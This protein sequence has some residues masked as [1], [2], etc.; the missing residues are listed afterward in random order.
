[1]L[2][3]SLHQHRGELD[4]IPK[5]PPVLTENAAGYWDQFCDV[6]LE[7]NH[8]CGEYLHDIYEMCWRIDLREKLQED[9]DQYGLMN[10]YDNGL[11]PNG[12]S[13]MIDKNDKR[14]TDLKKMY[15]LTLESRQ[16]LKGKEKKKSE[17]KPDKQVRNTGLKVVKDW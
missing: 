8:L 2:T 14:I 7:H 5:A 4:Y 1:M 16:L 13:G 10:V 11:Q 17:A 9:I 12:Y 3:E 15:G 6:L